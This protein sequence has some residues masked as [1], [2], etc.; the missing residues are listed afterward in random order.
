MK[1][2]MLICLA[3]GVCFLGT[4]MVV[5]ADPPCLTYDDFNA[6]MTEILNKLCTLEEYLLEGNK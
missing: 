1:S 3:M 6:T 4:L 5:S 2:S